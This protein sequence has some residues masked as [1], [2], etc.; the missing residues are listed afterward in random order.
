MLRNDFSFALHVS[1]R[2]LLAFSLGAVVLLYVGLFFYFDGLQFAAKWD[3]IRFWATSQTFSETLLP[4]LDLLRNYSELNTPLPFVLYGALEHLFG[5]GLFAGRLLNLTLCFVMTCLVCLPARQRGLAPVLAT[6]GLLLFPY[7]LYYSALLYTDHIAA[8]F[9]L[10]GFWWYLRDRHVLSALSFV[11][12]ISS[13]QYMLA[14]P[15]AVAAYEAAAHLRDPARPHLRWMAPLLAAA[16]ILG[17][18]ALFEGA[19]TDEA[20]V[21]RDSVP[22]FQRNQWTFVFTT[23]LYMLS[24]VGLYFVL[25][26]WL[27]FSRRV[28][29]KKFLT[30]K[31]LTIAL[32]LLLLFALFLG[33][34][35]HGL[36]AT[37]LGGRSALLWHGGLFVLAL[38]AC[39]RF[40]RLDLAF[41]LLLMNS[42]IMLK[43]FPWD[44]YALPLLV[45]LWYLKSTGRLDR[46]AAVSLRKNTELRQHTAS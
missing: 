11:L 12:A 34:I 28:R 30:F 39:F 10:L 35:G 15:L 31:H 8:F 2:R 45:V 36:L 19:T 3:E 7:Y 20:I 40:A 9:V 26:E 46:Q 24:C 17:W 23:P 38:L 16:S 44:K 21:S 18:M 1:N 42:L 37:A 41:W 13:R 14:F 25:P 4:S 5:G 33:P 43:A 6:C 27:L 29:L 32:G 22:E